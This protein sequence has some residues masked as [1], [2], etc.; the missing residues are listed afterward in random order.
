MGQK[1]FWDL[2][3]RQQELSQKKSILEE[4]NRVI[5]WESFREQLE[6]IHDKPRKSKAGRKPIDVIV[7]FKLL[8]LQQ[9]YN[10]SDE[11]LEYQVKDRLSFMRFTGLGLEDAVP[12]ATTVWL[13][14]KQLQEQGL[15]E[16]LFEQFELYLQERGYQAQGGQI[17][18]ATLIPVPKQRIN[19]EEK[20]HLEVGETP[21]HWQENRHRLVQK[22]T[23]AEWTKKNDKSYFGYKN[24]IS[25]DVKHGF[26][27]RYAVT[28]AAVHDSQQ[29]TAVLDGDNES[30]EVWADSAY[31]SVAIE[32]LLAALNFISH[33]HERA[34]RNRPLSEEQQE[35]NRERSQTRAKV[36]HVFGAWVMQLGGKLLRSIGLERAKVNLGLKNLTYNFIRL[37]FWQTRPVAG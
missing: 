35:A 13:F 16:R 17:I 7:M 37:V 27:R 4:L 29:L 33:I 30:D 15:V 28:G 36:E 12:D 32:G 34:Y 6:Q 31:R 5:P 10:I 11:E 20:A 24:H 25:I 9:L 22:D 3:K 21:P 23:D 14:R 18:D 2:E 8:V 1:G 19:K 26:I